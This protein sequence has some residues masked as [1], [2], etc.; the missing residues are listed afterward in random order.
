MWKEHYIKLVHEHAEDV[1]QIFVSAIEKGELVKTSD[2]AEIRTHSGTRNE[3][4]GG[5]N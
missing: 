5:D 2:I 3:R 4:R 1:A